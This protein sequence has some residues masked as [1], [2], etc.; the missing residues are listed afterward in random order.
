[1]EDSLDEHEINGR[2]PHWKMTSMNPNSME[3]D[4]NVRTSQYKKTLEDDLNEKIELT[5]IKNDKLN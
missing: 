3:Y 2:Q 4:L 5:S 1:M